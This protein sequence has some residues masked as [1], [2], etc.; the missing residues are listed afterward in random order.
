LIRVQINGLLKLIDNPSL[1]LIRL[2][3]VNNWLDELDEF[4]EQ[5]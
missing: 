5:I 2:K 4:L 3:Y 1:K